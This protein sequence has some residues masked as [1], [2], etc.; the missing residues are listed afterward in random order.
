MIHW[1]DA[2]AYARF[3]REIE[4]LTMPVHLMVGNHDDTTA[5]WRGFPRNTP[6]RKRFCPKRF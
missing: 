4:E 1:G 2:A 6:Q 5:F 3:L